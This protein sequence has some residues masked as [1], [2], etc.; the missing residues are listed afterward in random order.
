MDSNAFEIA[1]QSLTQ[2]KL[3]NE[4]V[5][6]LPQ[7]WVDF[8][9]CQLNVQVV[10]KTQSRRDAFGKWDAP[11]NEFLMQPKSRS[12][13][14]LDKW[15]QFEGDFEL[16]DERRS[17]D[18][19]RD[20]IEKWKMC[21]ESGYL[22]ESQILVAEMIEGKY[23]RATS[24]QRNA[25]NLRAL[26]PDAIS[27]KSVIALISSASAATE[28]GSSFRRSNLALTAPR[29]S[30]RDLN[31]HPERNEEPSHE[32]LARYV[33]SLGTDPHVAHHIARSFA[34]SQIELDEDGTARRNSLPINYC[35]SDMADAEGGSKLLNSWR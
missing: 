8:D 21:F 7:T 4:N 10:G 29:S 31:E 11:S 27:D 25:T 35:S 15:E 24:T 30:Y 18:D 34:Q 26:A 23:R 14:D 22:K 12:I 1:K 13:S 16:I 19:D 9:K 32:L 20:L 33:Q 17:P 5:N 2:E 3:E 6:K 28:R